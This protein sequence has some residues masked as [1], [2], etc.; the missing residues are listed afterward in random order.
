MS[1]YRVR[2]L[3]TG[4]QKGRAVELKEVLG[5]LIRG[6][7]SARLTKILRRVGEGE[8]VTVYETNSLDDAR[9]IAGRLTRAGARIVVDG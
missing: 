6:A 9:D 1:A 2:V 3:L 7:G 5:R 8:A 4:F